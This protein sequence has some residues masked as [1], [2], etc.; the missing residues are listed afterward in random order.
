[1]HRLSSDPRES[2]GN[3]TIDLFEA[4][5]TDRITIRSRTRLYQL[6][7]ATSP[8]T[9]LGFHKLNIAIIM[10]GLTTTSRNIDG[11]DRSANVLGTSPQQGSTYL[12]TGANRG[13][14]PMWDPMFSAKLT[15]SLS[16]GIGRGLA[17]ALLLRSNSTVIACVRDPT[18]TTA[19]DLFKLP[20]AAGSTLIVIQLDCANSTSAESAL[21]ALQRDHPDITGLDV[22]IANAAI[23]S[24]FG[25]TSTMPTDVLEK[26]MQVNCYSVLQLFQA[27]RPLLEKASSTACPSR[28]V[29]IGAPISTITNM[30]ETGRAPLGAYS[31]SKLAANFIMRKLHFEN[32][33]LTAFV[34]DP[35]YILTNIQQ[36]SGARADMFRKQARA[37]RHG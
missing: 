1:V 30:S 23:A 26:H 11:N 7:R 10:A 14:L 28:F 9:S 24:N 31:V 8:F 2:I 27:A 36:A 17:A 34:V 3:R 19:I 18:H 5:D 13:E 16:S 35:G 32:K 20:R 6:C 15:R 4:L 22:V 33:W 12:V 21:Q 37:D 29:F 25:P